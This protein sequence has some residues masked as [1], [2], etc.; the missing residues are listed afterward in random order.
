MAAVRADLRHGRLAAREAVPA[1]ERAGMS[2]Q[3]EA[4]LAGLVEARPPAVIGFCWPMK[5]EFDAWPLVGGLLERGWRA[6]LPVAERNATPL[7]FRPWSPDAAMATD[8]FGIPV[9][10]TLETVLPAIVLVPLV[11]FDDAGYRLG[12]G[13]GFFDRTLAGLS[14]R[15]LAIGVGFEVGRVSTVHPQAHDIPMDAIVTEKG[16]RRFSF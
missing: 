1:A 4:H 16:I 10:D 15:P 12:Y 9:P 7:V 13:G 6:A 2:A 11:A 14:P 5:G 3:I 8:M